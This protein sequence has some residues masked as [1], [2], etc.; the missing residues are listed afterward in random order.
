VEKD[1]VNLIR[2][3]RDRGEDNMMV[4]LEREGGCERAAILQSQF[5][6]WEMRDRGEDNMMVLLERE[7]G[8]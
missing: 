3:M 1:R 7:G 5:V 2:E 6:M 4:L 8:C